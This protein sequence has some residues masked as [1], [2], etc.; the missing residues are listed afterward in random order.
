MRQVLVFVAL[1]VVFG[2][3]AG[4]IAFTQGTSG[5]PAAGSFASPEASPEAS[6]VASP[7]MLAQA[8]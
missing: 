4:G 6:P 3:A 7:V 8:G 5:A 1:V 2:L